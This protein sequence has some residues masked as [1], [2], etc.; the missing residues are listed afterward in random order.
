MNYYKLMSA[1]HCA[2]P[3]KMLRVP[4]ELLSKHLE[5]VT[6]HKEILMQS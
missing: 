1:V 6:I 4:S 5:F 2:C 3:D